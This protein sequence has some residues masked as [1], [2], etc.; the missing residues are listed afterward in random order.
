MG[1]KSVRVVNREVRTDDTAVLTVEL[2][3]RTDTQ[4]GKLLMKKIGNEWKVAG[5]VQGESDQPGAADSRP[6]PV[7]QPPAVRGP[8]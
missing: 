7:N 1:M 4:T 8:N 6:N 2:E 3:G 5:H